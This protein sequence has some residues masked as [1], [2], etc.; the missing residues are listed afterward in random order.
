[1]IL[2]INFARPT[3]LAAYVIFIVFVEIV[4]YGLNTLTSKVCFLTFWIFFIIFMR[5]SK[6]KIFTDLIL[7]MK[8][9]EK[10]GRLFAIYCF[11]NSTID[12]ISELHQVTSMK[13]IIKLGEK[14]IIKRN[15]LQVRLNH[16]S[17]L[18]QAVEII[19]TI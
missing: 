6:Y 19:N 13:T 5:K 18:M 11:T 17:L 7:G 3:N 10:S 2:W 4:P 9:L 1:M 14:K 8:D 15:H 12:T 16:F